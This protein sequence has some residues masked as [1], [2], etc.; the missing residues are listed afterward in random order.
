MV[1]QHSL[2]GQCQRD[3]VERGRNREQNRLGVPAKISTTVKHPFDDRRQF[4]LTDAAARQFVDDDTIR[5]PFRPSRTAPQ[6]FCVRT[7]RAV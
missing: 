2:H 4:D 5:Q 3:L 7:P 1:V 6:Q